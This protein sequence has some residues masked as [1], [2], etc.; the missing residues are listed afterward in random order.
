MCTHTHT[1]THTHIYIV[2]TYM[3]ISNK[4]AKIPVVEDSVAYSSSVAGSTVDQQVIVLISCVHRM[5]I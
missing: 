5:F 2:S 1:H 3:T 4:C